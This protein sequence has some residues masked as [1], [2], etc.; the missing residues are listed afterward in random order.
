MKVLSALLGPFIPVILAGNFNDFSTSWFGIINNVIVISAAINLV[1]LFLAKGFYYFFSKL[2]ACCDRGCSCK[3]LSSKTVT[4][5]E[6]FN[7]HVGPEFPFE[8]KYSGVS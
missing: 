6:F 5:N 8:L 4:R 7:V 2:I 1:I 3:A